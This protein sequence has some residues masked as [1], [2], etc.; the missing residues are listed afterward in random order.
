MKIAPSILSEA[1]V[2]AVIRFTWQ[3]PATGKR[4]RGVFKVLKPH[5][6]EYFAED[7]D[8][9]QGLAQYFSDQHRNY[10]FPAELASRYLQES[11]PPAA[12]RS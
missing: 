5:I 4:E 6:P 11:P 7:M 9:L 12:A 10:G 8:Y 3:D 1:S 2:S